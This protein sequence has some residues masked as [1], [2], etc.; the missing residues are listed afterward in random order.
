MN[1][2][3]LNFSVSSNFWCAH[4]I[5]Y[6]YRY[7]SSWGEQPSVSITEVYI[8]QS[9]KSHLKIS[10]HITHLVE[11]EKLHLRND[12]FFWHVYVLR[13]S[14]QDVKYGDY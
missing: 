10:M 3:A 6:I 12:G 14:F 5:I 9:V 1:R 2:H 13:L 4:L 11:M 8:C 7:I